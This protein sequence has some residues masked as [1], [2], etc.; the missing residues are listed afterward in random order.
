MA[1][2]FLLAASCRVEA[3][4]TAVAEGDLL[5]MPSFQAT[6]Q[7]CEN[8]HLAAGGNLADANW[9]AAYF[10]TADGK[11]ICLGGPGASADLVAFM[12]SL[13]KGQTCAL[14]DAFI[15]FQ[16]SKAGKN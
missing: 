1:F 7:T 4:Y 10:T 2:L 12:R 16:K 11:R 6:V 5:R 9:V 3:P 8:G 14:P 15:S 13:R